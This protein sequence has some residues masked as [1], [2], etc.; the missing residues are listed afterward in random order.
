L[1]EVRQ[2]EG[3]GRWLR[4]LADRQ[5]KAKILVTVQRMEQGHFGDA[6]SVGPGVMETRIHVGPGYRLY[7]TRRG[8][9][10]VILLAGGDKSTQA[11]DIA[12]AVGLAAQ[13][14]DPR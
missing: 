7:Y 6:K 3:F 13:L 4:R 12:R 1:V 10:L 9:T 2:T 5:A 11:R 14:K 8:G